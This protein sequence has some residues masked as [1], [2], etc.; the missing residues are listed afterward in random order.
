[1]RPSSSCSRP[2][3]PALRLCPAHSHR[4]YARDKQRDAASS[5]GGEW[6]KCRQETRGCCT[7]RGERKMSI[8]AGEGLYQWTLSDQGG[9]CMVA[10]GRRS[11]LPSDLP[12]ARQDFDPRPDGEKGW[13]QAYFVSSRLFGEKQCVVKRKQ[14]SDQFILP[15]RALFTSRLGRLRELSFVCNYADSFVTIDTDRYR[16]RRYLSRTITAVPE[17]STLCTLL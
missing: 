4:P 15:W 16:L 11:D 14:L 13:E 3:T 2:R 5:R 7:C 8:V 9:S 12:S 10:R 1:M 6:P 17:S